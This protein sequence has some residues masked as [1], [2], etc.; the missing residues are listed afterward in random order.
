[1]TIAGIDNNPNDTHR[2]QRNWQRLAAAFPMAAISS[3]TEETVVDVVNELLSE[4]RHVGML[5]PNYLVDENGVVLVDE[6]GA[7]LSD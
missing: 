3:A 1:M 5:A 7:R 4:M 2:Q 6:N